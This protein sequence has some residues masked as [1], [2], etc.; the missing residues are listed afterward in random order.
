M[1]MLYFQVKS[2][3][4]TA[5]TMSTFSIPGWG[6]LPSTL[7]S[8]KWSKPSSALTSSFWTRASSVST[9]RS[10]LTSRRLKREKPN[11]M[12]TL[13]RMNFHMWPGIRIWGRFTYRKKKRWKVLF[14]FLL[15]FVLS[16]CD[17]FVHRYWGIAGG[18]VLSV[19]LAFDDSLKENG[20]LQ[21][22]PGTSA[23]HIRFSCKF[24]PLATALV[25][26]QLI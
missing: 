18:P 26:P 22:I 6:T 16:N 10:N 12:G 20:A 17:W 13:A 4:S 14:F 2:T 8:Y 5:S 23:T 9:Q 1:G 19:W 25:R 11:L 15:C 21:V 24:M 3:P 7:R